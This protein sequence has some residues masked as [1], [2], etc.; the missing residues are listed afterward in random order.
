MYKESLPFETNQEGNTRPNSTRH[1]PVDGAGR[2]P[3]KGILELIPGN[4][5]QVVDYKRLHQR[6]LPQCVTACYPLFQVIHL[7]VG[8]H[9][10]LRTICDA[11]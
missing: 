10:V 9:R 6:K 5:K 3:A 11:L 2:S 4:L 7:T 1:Q 8:K